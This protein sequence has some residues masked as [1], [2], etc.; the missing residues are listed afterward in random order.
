VANNGHG[1]LALA[2]SEH[3]DII[4]LD[5]EMPDMYGGDIARIL[6]E[7]PDTKDIPVMFLTGMFL[8][9]EEEDKEG[10]RLIGGYLLFTKPYDIE[11]LVATIKKLMGEKASVA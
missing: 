3:P 10:G 5:L 7:D 4:I 8:K 6:K 11:E 9:E 2:K 1:A